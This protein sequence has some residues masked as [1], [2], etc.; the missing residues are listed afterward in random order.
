MLPGECMP[1]LSCQTKGE[2]TTIHA[3]ARESQGLAPSEFKDHNLRPTNPFWK[4]LPHCNIFS[5]ITPDMLHQLHKG[6]F[7][8]HILKWAT[9]STTGGPAEIDARFQAMSCH[10]TLWHFKKGISMMMQW[11]GNEHK[12]MEKVFLGTL[13]G[14]V[15]DEVLK[16]VRRV[17]DFIGYAHFETHCNELLAEMD[18]AWVAFHEVKGI[19]EDLEIWKH[20]NISKLHNIKH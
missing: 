2:G 20:F 6:V 14:A 9:Q 1:D 16:A 18:R 13:I 7:K 15:D 3:L 4:D 12:N 10:P 17:L 8:D 19:F 11:T 5:C